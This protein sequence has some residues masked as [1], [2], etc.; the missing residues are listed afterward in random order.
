MTENHIFSSLYVDDRDL[1]FSRIQE[2]NCLQV[3][4]FTGELV[5]FPIARE[6]AWQKRESLTVARE[7]AQF[8]SR[9][10]METPSG[11]SRTPYQVQGNP[12]IAG[13]KRKREREREEW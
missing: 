8:L 3:G 10:K 13:T 4:I 1:G 2:G 12:C 5:S 6:A 9:R 7:P 11:I